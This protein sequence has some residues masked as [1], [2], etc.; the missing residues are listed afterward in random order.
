MRERLIHT[1]IKREEVQFNLKKKEELFKRNRLKLIY[2]I[3]EKD[4]KITLAK[5]QKLK[6]WE[7][8]RKISK[9]FEENREKLISKFKEIMNK[10]RKK[11]KEQIVSELLNKKMEIKTLD[12]SHIKDN[13]LTIRNLK[14]KVDNKNNRD[15]HTFL[16]N[17]SMRQI[18][19]YRYKIN[20][21]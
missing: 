19:N 10:R 1:A 9:N 18:K 12:T 13:T 11:S 6:V 16:T 4:K 5:S 7:E 3:S 15:E 14:K 20:D 2:E 8:Q 17:L 21:D